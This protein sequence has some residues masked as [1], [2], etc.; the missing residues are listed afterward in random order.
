[1]KWTRKVVDGRA[2]WYSGSFKV[3]RLGLNAGFQTYQVGQRNGKK[4]WVPVG[5]GSY[6]LSAAKE[7]CLSMEDS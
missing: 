3:V 5:F 4:L 1:M 7:L 2:A 6:S